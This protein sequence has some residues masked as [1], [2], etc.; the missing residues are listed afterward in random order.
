VA[1]SQNWRDARFVVVDVEG[2]GRQPPDIVEIGI[3]AIENGEVVGVPREWL[4]KPAERI[5]HVVTR[6]HGITN[7]MVVSVPRFHEIAA[8]V[9]RSLGDSYVIAHNAKIEIDILTPKLAGWKPRGVIDT[10]K[11]ARRIMPGRKSYA[12]TALTTDLR[13]GSVESGD[14]PR[15]HRVAH[16]VMVTARLFLRLASDDTGS[17]RALSVLLGEEPDSLAAMPNADTPSQGGLFD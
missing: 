9:R 12:L 3:V 2:N 6:L 16:D 15:A 11:L 14:T 8:D 13:L 5:S 1:D 17:P 7:E 10:L 4:V